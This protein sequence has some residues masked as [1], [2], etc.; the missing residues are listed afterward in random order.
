MTLYDDLVVI[1]AL[2][3]FNMCS[4]AFTAGSASK[5]P[6]DANPKAPY[7]IIM[8]VSKSFVCLPCINCIMLPSPYGF[9][10][11]HSLDSAYVTC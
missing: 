2:C 10:N 8:E 3:I 7:A 9:V 5:A 4:R 1:I 6:K 11:P